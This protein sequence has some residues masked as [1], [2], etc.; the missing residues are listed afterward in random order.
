MDTNFPNIR[1]MRVF[2]EAAR[3]GSV[4]LAAQHC[5]LSQP[6]ATQAISR[7]EADLGVPLLVRRRG[8]FA[9][10]ECGKVFQIR[11]VAALQHLKDGAQRADR[12]AGNGSRPKA[13]I[14]KSITVAQLRN[15]IAIA[16]HGSFTVAARSLGISQP[17]IH[18][19]ARNLEAI[20]GAPLFTAR[21]F[22]VSLTAAAEALVLGAKLAV[23]EIRQANAE[24]DSQT[25]METGNFV[26][27]SL[28]L[29]RTIIVPRAIHKMVDA[30]SGFQIRVVDGRYAELLRSLREGDLD[31]LIGALRFPPPADDIEQERLFTDALAIVAHPAHPLAQRQHLSLEDTLT[32][33][34]IAPPKETPAGQ[35]LFNTLKINELPQTPVRA[36]SSSMVTL[37]GILAQ[38]N[39]ISIVSRHQISFEEQQGTIKALHVALEDHHREIGLTFRKGWRPTNMQAQFIDCLRQSSSRVSNQDLGK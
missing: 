39:Y 26:L 6:A 1:H 32:Y 2:L 30:T 3:S 38:G 36:V 21:P 24:I 10:T 14:D 7:L 9:L 17:T 18:R 33:P 37:R 19:A 25:G 5:H 31:C 27:G 16:N 29:A 12:V 22:G 35:Y 8:N 15:L 20:V 4:S 13:E 11:A 23:A 34:W 28:P